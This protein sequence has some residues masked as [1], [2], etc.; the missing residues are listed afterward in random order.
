MLKPLVAAFGK[1]PVDEIS[2]VEIR[3]WYASL[4]PTKRTARA[5]QYALL[6]N[7]LNGAVDD[8]LIEVNPCRIRA[9][10]STKRLRRIQPAT[11]EQLANLV[12]EMPDR[13]RVLILAAAWCALRFGEL[14]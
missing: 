5:H 14:T 11:L 13:Y 4:D 12:A 1:R 7:I 9:A 3:A 6:H 8:E 10:G 2:N